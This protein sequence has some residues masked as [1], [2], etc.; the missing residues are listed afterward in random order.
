M[1]LMDLSQSMI[2]YHRGMDWW[3]MDETISCNE[4]YIKSKYDTS[5]LFV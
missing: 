2:L 1:Y 3:V 5:A 4:T